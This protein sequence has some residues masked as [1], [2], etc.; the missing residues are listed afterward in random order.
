MPCNDKSPLG[1]ACRGVLR[2]AGDWPGGPADALPPSRRGVSTERTESPVSLPSRCCPTPP[3]NPP[4]VADEFV[5]RASPTWR[6]HQRRTPLAWSA[7]CTG[8]PAVGN[9]P[10]R[11]WGTQNTR[12]RRVGGGGAFPRAA[13]RWVAGRSRP[14]ALCAE[15]TRWPRWPPIGRPHAAARGW[16]RP[17]SRR[18]A[19][20]SGPTRMWGGHQM[21]MPPGGQRRTPVEEQADVLLSLEHWACYLCAC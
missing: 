2:V 3:L 16:K 9:G 12:R 7:A 18:P 5:L 11:E 15:Q 21:T 10:T 13:T 8:A 4:I 20:L 1:S 17:S 6:R 19:G 14:P